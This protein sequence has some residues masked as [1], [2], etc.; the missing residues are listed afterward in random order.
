MEEV[1]AESSYWIARINPNDKYHENA[2]QAMSEL[3]NVK[4][5]TSD[6]VWCE[7]FAKFSRH[8]E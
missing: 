3:R 6:S 2:K 4:I 5:V 1:F 7:V 8:G